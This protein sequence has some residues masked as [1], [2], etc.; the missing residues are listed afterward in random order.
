MLYY[1]DERDGPNFAGWWFGPKVG[2]DQVWAYHNSRAAQTPPLRGWKVPYDGPVDESFVIGPVQQNAQAYQGQAYQQQAASP[3]AFPALNYGNHAQGGKGY[4]GPPAAPANAEMQRQQQQAMMRQQHEQQRAMQA[5]QLKQQEEMKLKQ[6]EMERRRQE[7]QKQIAERKK[8]EQDAS[9]II[10]AAVQKVRVAK[11]EVFQQAEQELYQTMQKELTHCGYQMP[12]IREE[13][14]KAVEQA[15]RRLEEARQQKIFEEQRKAEMAAKALQLVEEFK[16]KVDAAEE[17]ANSLAE[18]GEP[19]TLVDS[20]LQMP[21]AEIEE[22]NSTVEEAKAEADAKTKQCQDFLIEHGAAM[23]VP[24]QSV[25]ESLAKLNERL[26]V[27]TT[28]KES[29]LVKC[30]N[31]KNKAEKKAQAKKVMAAIAA[32]FKSF[33]AN[34]DGHLDK[35]EIIAYAKK[36]FKFT[37]KDDV[38]TKVLKAL[39]VGA[40]GVPESDFQRLKVRI[41]ILREKVKDDERRKVREAREVELEGMKD[42]LKEK[43][44]EAEGKVDA[45]EEAVKKVEAALEGVGKVETLKSSELRSKSEEVAALTKS[46]EEQVAGVRTEV[47]GI[48]EGAEPDLK[49]WLNQTCKPLDGKL[50]GFSTRIATATRKQKHLE[51]DAKN[52]D[53]AEL[54]QSEKRVLA[55]LRQHQMAKSLA[56]EELF[57]SVSKKD[58]EKA[59]KESFVAFLTS[60]EAEDGAEAL[61]EEEVG[62]FFDALDAEKAGSLT[63]E[64]MLMLIRSLKKVVKETTITQGPNLAEEGDASAVTKLEAGDVVELL[65]S[66]SE[67]GDMMRAQCRSMKDGSKGW[68]TL[69]GNQGTVHL[70]D[71]GALWK[72]LKET[73]LTSTFEIDS[74]EAKEL[75]KQMVD[76]TRKLRPGEVVEVREWMRKEEKSGLMRMKC[77]AKL[78]GKVGWVT[79]VGNAGTVFLTVQ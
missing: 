54:L 62:R 23:R 32:K 36:E 39:Q 67:E 21:E 5:Q 3:P 25:I 77:K 60:C 8:K 45:V 1:W 79:A 51:Q 76:N 64:H 75:S 2:G 14:E 65:S 42:E 27:T 43:I 35:K 12:K 10:R 50:H 78:D 33:D 24:D 15:K 71:G 72:V 31:A 49:I 57:L 4:P 55:T 11:E 74:E 66:P 13:C 61:T 18:K 46:A 53:A 63:K 7:Q 9:N 47:A 68:V 48:R 6:Q 26:K 34:K 38:A 40:K 16:V 30:R 52:K 19:L 58:E 28:S 17:A 29:V 69:K 56:P 22:A 59:T 20:I 41:G 73:S 37:M 44:A 70:A